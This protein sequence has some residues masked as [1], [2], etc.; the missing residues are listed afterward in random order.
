MSIFSILK[1]GMN[2]S[3]KM[4]L[5]KNVSSKPETAIFGSCVRSLLIVSTCCL[6]HVSVFNCC[7]LSVVKF[8]CELFETMWLYSRL[9]IQRQ[10]RKGIQFIFPS[11]STFN[12]L[13][14]EA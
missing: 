5:E 2:Y 13:E 9:N 4:N 8:V 1:E 10:H 3:E 11:Y 12:G 6:V 14:P 7:V